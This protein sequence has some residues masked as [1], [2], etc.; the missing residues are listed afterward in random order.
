MPIPHSTCKPSGRWTATQTQAAYPKVMAKRD[1]DPSCKGRG[2]ALFSMH[3]LSLLSDITCLPALSCQAQAHSPHVYTGVN[4]G[5]YSLQQ[6][7]GGFLLSQA[8]GFHFTKSMAW[9]LC[10]WAKKNKRYSLNSLR[11]CFVLHIFLH[12]ALNVTTEGNSREPSDGPQISTLV[13]WQWQRA[14]AQPALLL[15]PSLIATACTQ[16]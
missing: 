11:L 8:V 13:W 12:P 2:R 16:Q 4:P 6:V 15:T 3:F 7:V 14:G 5:M 9:S 10:Y 1:N